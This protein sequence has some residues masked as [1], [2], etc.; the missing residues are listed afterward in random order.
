[1]PKLPSLPKL[2]PNPLKTAVTG[3][4]RVVGRVN[5][6][7]REIDAGVR[8]LDELISSPLTTA[9]VA[10]E[11]KTAIEKIA[12]ARA[13][14]SCADD[15]WSTISGALSE[16]LRFARDEGISSDQV[17]GRIALARDEMNI[18]ERV[19]LQPTAIAQLSGKEK[20]LALWSLV[21]SRDFRHT[22]GN[23]TT[24]DDLE[25]AAARA[26]TLSEEHSKQYR[27]IRLSHREQCEECPSILDLR[28][29]L[30]ERQKGKGE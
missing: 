11:A 22:V 14:L 5:E 10:E 21:H 24:V 1:M 7:V 18:M 8:E 13:C 2:P 3:A 12:S 26:K 19:D 20:E 4:K 25:R 9:P 6:V 30:E 23:I 17:Q 29:F 28:R 15:H 27:Q 16:A